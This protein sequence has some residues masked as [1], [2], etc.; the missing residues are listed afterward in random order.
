MEGYE[1]GLE[2]DLILKNAAEKYRDKWGHDKVIM[3]LDN[4]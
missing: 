4:S 3:K 1:E 2:K